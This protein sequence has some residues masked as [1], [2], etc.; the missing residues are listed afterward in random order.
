[1]WKLNLVQILEK[2]PCQGKEF[3]LYFEATDSNGRFLNLSGQKMALRIGSC[4]QEGG[5]IARNEV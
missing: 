1:M 5:Y 3:K 4:H 2:F